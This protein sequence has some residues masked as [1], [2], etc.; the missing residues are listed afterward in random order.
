MRLRDLIW[1]SAL[2]ILLA[3]WSDAGNSGAIML[4]VVGPTG[5]AVAGA[6]VAVASSSLIAP[7]RATTGA[8]GHVVVPALPPGSYRVTV[9]LS[10]YEEAE[11]EIALV[12][13][14]TVD[15]VIPLEVEAVRET[16]VV[17]E[18]SPAVD[19]RSATVAAHVTVAQVEAI[20]IG[21][22]YRAYAQLVPGV[23]VVP[24]SD[25]IETR[26]EPAS[27]SGN[28]YY[29]RG[30]AMGSRDNVYL[31]D[32]FNLT[33][34]AGGTGAMALDNDAILEEE[35]IT[36]GV[37]A[38][39]PGGS[40]YLANIVTRLG[41]PTTSGS[42]DYFLQTPSMYDRFAT[43]DSRL[44][45]AREDKRDGGFTIGGPLARDRAWYFAAGQERSN[46]DDVELSASASPA[47]RRETYRFRRT[48][49]LGKV[50]VRPGDDSL[51]TAVVFADLRRTDGSRDVNLPPNRYGEGR[52]D[53]L[54]YGLTYRRTLAAGTLV[55]LQLFDSRRDA[56]TVPADPGAGPMNT[57]L[58]G[59][60]TTV[61]AYLRDLGSSG[62]PSRTVQRKRQGEIALT[63][64]AHALGDHQ[65]KAGV[66]WQRW[67]EANSTE[68]I[69]GN[70]MTSLAAPLA[71][72]TVGGA[73]DLNLLPASEADVIYRALLAAPA[74]AA[75]GA[76]DTDHNGVLT[77]A[78]FA[79]AAFG[80]TAG[81][82][83]GVNFLRQQLEY[84]GVNN[85][86]HTDWA[87]FLQD[88]WR[89]GRWSVA[90]GTRV[91]K[92]R[93]FASDGSTILAMSPAVYPRL[94]VAWDVGGDGRQKLSFAYGRYS[95]PLLSPMVR[96][97]GNLSGSI[98][99][100]EV[101]LGGS[102]FSYRTR[103]SATLAR[104]AGFAPDLKNQVAT[105]FQLAY[106]VNL[107]P[108]V[109]F[110]AQLYHRREDNLIEDYDPAVYFNPAV[111]GR[112]ALTPE[113]FGY[114]ASGPGAV[115]YFLGNL[116]GGK[117]RAWGVDLS[118]ERRF[119][120]AWGASLQYSWKRAEGNSTSNGDANLQGD[121]ID[122]DP[123]QPY[124]Y[125]PL[126]G[127]I[128]HQVKAFGSYRTRWGVEVGA[129]AYWNSGAVF[130]ESDLFRPGSYDIAYNHRLPDGSYVRAGSERQPAYATVDLR[131]GYAL[132]AGRA[133]RLKLIV[134]VMNATNNQGALRIEEAHN[135]PDF[136]Y[137]APRLLLAPRRY[138]LG[139]QY[140]W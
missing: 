48:N 6:A 7:R 113:D 104:D 1:L 32:G 109:S 71:G 10:G 82:T 84:A 37:P 22:D 118:L 52:D 26:Y 38:E 133:G 23:N 94:G 49:G 11:R 98:W 92:V 130:T 88:D 40:G 9:K 116:V 134:D 44:R 136:A 29:D 121:F 24:N 105:E 115:N 107:T 19:T 131:L 126:P 42:L 25:G 127:T 39:Y 8:E 36:S 14:R 47:A 33:D 3:S 64:F 129:L 91:E 90:A 81:N 79:A 12:Q 100:D 34:M 53:T 101:F 95:D 65:I 46:S 80:S 56:R 138:Q 120:G 122:L 20:P 102:W 128:E 78:E 93:Y 63:R 4:T 58:Y 27:K 72:L 83:A 86:G 68:R 60:G 108:R 45:G 30:A 43:G 76:L 74:S 132:P 103:G 119:A 140:T 55:E 114:T 67:E 73:R 111:A 117:R 139:V 61:P 5:A 135:S 110:L 87:F 96:F 21:R 59:P 137:R 62:D 97:A 70:S 75:F 18:T 123:R 99:A 31:L 89:L 85:V 35:V 51:L 28:F 112:L 69:F 2:A 41:G 57:V 16:I 54:T 77:P 15:L 13:D 125:G 106:G 124:M 17:R 66:Q 50:T